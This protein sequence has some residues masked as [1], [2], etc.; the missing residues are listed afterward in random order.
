M[1]ASLLAIF[2]KIPWAIVQGVG[3]LLEQLLKF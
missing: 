3:Q 2:D 1:K